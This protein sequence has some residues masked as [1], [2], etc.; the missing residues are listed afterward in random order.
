MIDEI[1]DDL[2]LEL[3]KVR[4]TGESD[5]G[6]RKTKTREAEISL[7]INSRR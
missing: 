4:D 6:T 7:E 5:A 3:A 1:E 2:E